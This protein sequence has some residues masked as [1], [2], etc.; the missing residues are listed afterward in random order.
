MERPYGRPQRKRAEPERRSLCAVVF[1]MGDGIVSLGVHGALL[2]EGI[3][4]EVSLKWPIQETLSGRRDDNFGFEVAWW[5]F[6]S[7]KC[8]YSS[9]LEITHS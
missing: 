2:V 5:L 3:V 8:H 1:W 6:V 7:V 9:L 4:G